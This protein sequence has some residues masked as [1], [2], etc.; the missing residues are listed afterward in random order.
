MTGFGKARDPASADRL[1]HPLT[2]LLQKLELGSGTLNCVGWT[3][4]NE[5]TMRTFLTDRI[6]FILVPP[7]RQCLTRHLCTLPMAGCGVMEPRQKKLRKLSQSQHVPGQQRLKN[8]GTSWK[9]DSVASP[10]GQMKKPKADRCHGNGGITGT[11]YDNQPDALPCNDTNGNNSRSISRIIC[12]LRAI[13]T[14]C[15]L[16]FDACSK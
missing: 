9:Q 7:T 10:H 12:M 5:M 3:K 6:S 4:I 11:S 13:F 1:P 14:S 15:N 16:H 2:R 8:Q